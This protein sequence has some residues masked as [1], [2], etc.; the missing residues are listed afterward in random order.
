[1]RMKAPS[2]YS[3]K[4]NSIVA[5]QWNLS[6]FKKGELLFVGT[7]EEESAI[8]AFNAATGKY[9]GHRKLGFRPKDMKYFKGNVYILDSQDY[10]LHIYPGGK[11]P[12]F[13]TIR[14]A[15]DYGVRYRLSKNPPD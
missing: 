13:E 2:P 1:M 14:M 7:G 11:G 6:L 9:F 15:E 8:V 12:V 4:T 3:V 10:S 5:S